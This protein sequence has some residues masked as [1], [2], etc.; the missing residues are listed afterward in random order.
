MDVI[1]TKYP[2]ERR[3]RRAVGSARCRPPRSRGPRS[4]PRCRRATRA[5]RAFLGAFADGASLSR[6]ARYLPRD[7]RVG[8]R[9]PRRASPP[10][11][12]GAGGRGERD[13]RR[14]GVRPGEVQLARGRP[15]RHPV[16]APPGRVPRGEAPGATAEPVLHEILVPG[17]HRR[18][19][20]ALPQ[21][22][23]RQRGRPR[24]AQVHGVRVRLLLRATPRAS[25]TARARATA[26]KFLFARTFEKGPREK[27]LAGVGRRQPQSAAR[28]RHDSS[29]LHEAHDRNSAPRFPRRVL[30]VL[31]RRERRVA[32]RPGSM[33]V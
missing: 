22:H 7:S 9:S 30:L 21:P 4:R 15:E 13:I 2:S 6:R 17:Q 16:R 19:H 26:E 24:A 27:P 14:F 3:G 28:D 10:D 25:T 20:A 32:F 8:P 1:K 5:P 29:S 18:P 23:V 11:A 33:R 31:Q 12:R